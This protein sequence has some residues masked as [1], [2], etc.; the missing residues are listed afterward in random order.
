MTGWGLSVMAADR[1][2]I[3]DDAIEAILVEEELAVAGWEIGEVWGETRCGTF[4][5]AIGLTSQSDGSFPEQLSGK[6][7]QT[8]EGKGFM[9]IVGDYDA[10]DD[11]PADFVADIAIEGKRR[12]VILRKTVKAVAVEHA[13]VASIETI[14]SERSLRYVVRARYD[15][16]AKLREALVNLSA[17][18]EVA[19]VEGRTS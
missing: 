9:V 18:N 14:K 15:A 8:L 11:G 7:R 16:T 2:G 6:I 12:V 10:P 5:L 1:P 4:F 17:E 19:F 3:V 13:N